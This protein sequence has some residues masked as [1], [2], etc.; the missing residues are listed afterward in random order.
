MI[1]RF[2]H[3]LLLRRHF[4]R[5]ATFSEIAEL[6]ASRLLRMLAINIAASF[7]SIYLYQQGYSVVFIVLFWAAF[8]LF[9]ALM[10]IP[11]AAV[12][13]WIGPKHAILLSNILFIP[14]MVAFALLPQYG[15]WLLIVVGVFQ[16]FSS[17]MYA[18]AYN[19]DL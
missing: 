14:S 16:G 1:Q 11:S 19:I 7:M 8:F 13:A 18:I 5:H 10:S 15:A 3:G 4:W 17:A 9:K 12:A 6:Y 2:I